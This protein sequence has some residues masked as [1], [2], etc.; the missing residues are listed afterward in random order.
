MK[1]ID[2][3]I[4]K[5]VLRLVN[6]LV[7]KK[8]SEIADWSKKKRLTEKEIK[9]AI[10]EYGQMIIFPPANF[11]NE[12]DVIEIATSKSKKWSVVF[13]LWTT[14]DGKSDLSVEIT[15]IDSSNQYYDIEVDN[16]HTL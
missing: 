8:Y 14:E 1:T 5:T 13:P 16:I 15:V 11:L 10:D 12:I 3:K 2:Q 4:Y 7:D 9:E 6:L